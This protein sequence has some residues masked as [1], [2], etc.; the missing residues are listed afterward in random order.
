MANM[1]VLRLTDFSHTF[2]TRLKGREMAKHFAEVVN[3][4]TAEYL[5]VVWN[6]VNTASPSFIDEFIGG[7]QE[8]CWEN[9]T[10]SVVF[11]GDNA[12]INGLL[13]AVLTRRKFPVLHVE[14]VHHIGR[15]QFGKLGHPVESS[16]LPV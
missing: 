2:A 7:M 4:T 9:R 13:D 8:A 16:V 3:D 6:N 10:K 11:T 15:C 1:E 14:D 5:V 12:Y